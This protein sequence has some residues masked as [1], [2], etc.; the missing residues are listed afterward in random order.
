MRFR[1]L[2]SAPYFLAAIDRYR[3][4]FDQHDAETVVPVVN[5]RLS[6]SELLQ[7]VGDIDG[8]IAGDDCFS[9]RVIQKAAPRLRVISKWGTGIDSFDRDACREFGVAI[10]NT[11]GA[12][13]D[14]VADSVLGY[15]LSFARNIPW[16]D[17][18]VKSGRWEKLRGF[19]LHEATLGIVGVGRIGRAVAHRARA[20]GMTLLGHDIRPV[21]AEVL[22]T[23]GMKMVA[24]EE[25]LRR[26]DLVSLNCDL[27]PTSYHL[28][29]ES[30]LAMMKDTAVLINTARGPIVDEN[31]LTRALG[32]GLIAGAGLDVFE[33]EPLPPE[34]PLRKMHRV[35]LA[36]H[37]SNSSP[38]AWVRVHENTLKNLFEVLEGAGQ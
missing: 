20:F 11:P 3:S 22:D 24:F 21:P 28:I 25:L 8:V 29:N 33:I 32:R 13:T 17:R 35:L 7:I 10:R 2:V 31:A 38:S 4:V 23:T 16:M 27:N 14:A 19:A 15:V 30:A 37:N 1:I 34:S 18:D 12:F 5:E 36:P 9:R 26:S 6:E